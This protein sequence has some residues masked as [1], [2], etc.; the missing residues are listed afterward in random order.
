MADKM[1]ELLARRPL[2]PFTVELSREQVTEFW[3]QGFTRLARVT[4]DEEIVWLR[5]VYDL[6][7]SGE[8]ELAPLQFSVG[9]TLRPADRVGPPT[10]QLLYPESIC[11]Q[12]RDTVFFRNTNLV[13]RRLFGEARPLSGWGHMVSKAAGTKEIIYW[14]QDEAYWDPRRDQ[15]GVSC[16]M[17]LDPATVESGAMTFIPGSHKGPLLKHGFPGDDPAVTALMLK[18]EIDTAPAVPWPVPVGGLSLHHNR[19]LHTSG[20]NRTANVRR[21]YVNVWSPPAVT[22]EV[23][24][25]RP[26]YWQKMAWINRMKAQA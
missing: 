19:T 11:P 6:L 22:R 16:W 26:W 9:G 20:P 1:Q 18:E 3:E 14:H 15:E 24:Y 7:F 10:S 23:P 8:L 25:D 5:E 13:A 4:T 17:A 12:L 21:A 2:H